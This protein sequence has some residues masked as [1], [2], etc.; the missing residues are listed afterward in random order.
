MSPEQFIQGIR[1]RTNIS[2]V[3]AYKLAVAYAKMNF[4]T[5]EKQMLFYRELFTDQQI[6]MLEKDDT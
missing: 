4:L 1:G 6:A 5:I 3:E 2:L